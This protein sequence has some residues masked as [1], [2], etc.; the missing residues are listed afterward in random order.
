MYTCSGAESTLKLGVYFHIFPNFL[1]IS[2]SGGVT[3]FECKVWTKKVRLLAI[4]YRQ[5]NSFYS[6]FQNFFDDFFCISPH[7]SKSLPPKINTPGFGTPVHMHDF[8]YYSITPN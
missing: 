4:F 3:N 2:E 1:A 7:F 5:F 6:I 8:V